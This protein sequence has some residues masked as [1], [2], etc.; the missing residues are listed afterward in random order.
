MIIA[1]DILKPI[2]LSNNPPEGCPMVDVK[3]ELDFAHGH[4]TVGGYNDTPDYKGVTCTPVHFACNEE[5][6]HPSCAV[7]KIVNTVIL[8]MKEYRKRLGLER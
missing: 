3:S 1:D 6:I 7:C 8:D 4:D 2:L 5:I